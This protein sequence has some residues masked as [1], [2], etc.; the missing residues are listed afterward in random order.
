MKYWFL[1]MVGNDVY[2]VINSDNLQNAEK[3]LEHLAGKKEWDSHPNR[4]IR[5]IDE[6]FPNLQI[7]F[8]H[9][10]G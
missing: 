6:K 3:E 10:V 9:K 5:M 1:F 4:S 7:I 8:N 2:Y